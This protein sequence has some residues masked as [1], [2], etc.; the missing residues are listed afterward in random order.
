MG[1]NREWVKIGVDV[2]VKFWMG[3]NFGVRFDSPTFWLNLI[4]TEKN[5]SRSEISFWGEVRVNFCFGP[6]FGTYLFWLFI[7]RISIFFLD[8]F[9]NSWM[10]IFSDE[11]SEKIAKILFFEM[12]KI[13]E[14]DISLVL[15]SAGFRI[16]ALFIFTWFFKIHEFRDFS[17]NSKIRIRF[18]WI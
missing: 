2:R 7:S 4:L 3:W 17:M 14:I 18:F 9:E 12:I 1:W 8:F 5:Y 16:N 6:N 13:D 11:I 15:S 10:E